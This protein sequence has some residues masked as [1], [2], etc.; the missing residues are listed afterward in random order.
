M[1]ASSTNEKPTLTS[2]LSSSHM[3]RTSFGSSVRV[4]LWNTIGER[5][6]QSSWTRKLT[7]CIGACHEIRGRSRPSSGRD[8]V[9]HARLK[10]LQLFFIVYQLQLVAC[11]LHFV[12]LQQ[13]HIIVRRINT[14]LG[15]GPGSLKFVFG[16]GDNFSVSNGA[17]R[18]FSSTS[19]LRT[20]DSS[21]GH[22]EKADGM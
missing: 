18:S 10:L 20:R 15:E 1:A 9:D 8:S 4:M 11:F 13:W 7:P 16:S 2:S 5:T 14:S 6:I 21:P 22:S 17:L 19:E 12:L 3:T